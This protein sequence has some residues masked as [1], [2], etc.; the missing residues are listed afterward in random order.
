MKG[1]VLTLL[2]GYILESRLP[3]I[4]DNRDKSIQIQK[5]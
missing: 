5:K 4:V 2:G 1:E 3:F